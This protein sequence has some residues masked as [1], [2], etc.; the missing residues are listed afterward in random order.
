MFFQLGR[1][2]GRKVMPVA[3]KGKLIWQGITGDDEQA[4]AAENELGSE[5]LRELLPSLELVKAPELEL[6]VSEITKRLADALKRDGRSF[7]CRIFRERQPAAMA[8]PGGNIFI[9]DGLVRGCSDRDDEL[10]FVIAH[11]MAHVFCKHVWNRMVSDAA[12]RVASAAA[13]KAGPMGNWLRTKG[14]GMLKSAHSR[15]QEFDADCEGNRLSIAAAFGREGPA[16]FLA[17]LAQAERA[18]LDLGPY[19]SSHP[20]PAQRIAMLQRRAGTAPRE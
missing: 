8:L 7:T 15:E 19:V 3:R 20:P 12:L 18:G 14:F 2:L 11:E 17:R 1:Q 13:V 4:L 16:S 9:S 10:A 5:M 6:Y